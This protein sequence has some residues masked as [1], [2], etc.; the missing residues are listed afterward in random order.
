[1]TVNGQTVRELGTKADPS[2]DRIAVEGRPLRAAAAP[3]YLLLHK[4]VGVMTTLSD[5][6]GRPTVRDVLKGV[7]ERIYPV[8]RLDFHSAGLLL[9]TNDGAL[10]M[11]LTHPRFGVRK[12]YR[13]KVRGQPDERQVRRLSQGIQL[14]EGKTAPADVRVVEARDK[15]AWLEIVIAEGKKRQVRRMCDAVGLPVEKLVRIAYGPLK[16]GKLAAGEW[17]HLT[18]AEVAKLHREST[19]EAKLARGELGSREHPTGR[20]AR[21]E[22]VDRARGDSRKGQGKPARKSHGRPPPRRDRRSSS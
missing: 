5:P 9:L 13:V 8:G 12:V 15:K 1:V 19:G 11:R 3:I 7:R 20:G 22:L 21:I 18:E 4:P 2:R 14:E 10:A 17:R 6:E 16:L